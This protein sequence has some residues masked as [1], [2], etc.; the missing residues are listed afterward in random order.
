MWPPQDQL[1]R[2]LYSKGK[3]THRGHEER[4]GKIKVSCGISERPKQADDTLVGKPGGPC[5]VTIADR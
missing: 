5:L 4:R 1:R 2:H 3:Q